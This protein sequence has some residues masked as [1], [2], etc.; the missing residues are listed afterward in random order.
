[1]LGVRGLEGLV[2]AVCTGS[3]PIL[4]VF[5]YVSLRIHY[6]L[7]FYIFEDVFR[8]EYGGCLKGGGWAGFIASIIAASPFSSFASCAVGWSIVLAWFLAWR[9]FL[10]GFEAWWF[11]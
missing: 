5:S 9:S 7:T 11:L 6:T 2:K 10:P 8:M 3:S 4:Y 1:M